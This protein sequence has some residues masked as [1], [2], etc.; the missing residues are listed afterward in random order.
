VITCAGKRLVQGNLIP[1]GQS[2]QKSLEKSLKVWQDLPAAERKAGAVQIGERGALDPK[3]LAQTAPAD[4]LVLRVYN[5]HLGRDAKG[6]LRFTVP[7]DYLPE[8]RR[9]AA[10][11]R[12]SAN[13]FMW[14][15]AKEWQAMVPANPKAGDRVPV[16]AT[17]AER[18]WRW[19]LDPATGMGEGRNFVDAATGTGHLNLVIEDVTA[20]NIQLRLEG[21]AKL[22]NPRRTLPASYE[23]ALVGHLT[24]DRSKKAFSRFDLV[25][26]GD[27]RGSPAGENRM[28]ERIGAQPL[29]IVFELAGPGA[30]VHLPAPRGARDHTER[31]L[32]PK[33]KATP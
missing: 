6:E 28:G 13:D 15:T 24:Y 30:S 27:V 11:F 4:C 3:R 26:L 25:A 21:S 14:V 8:F 12:E 22:E 2:F 32:S 29:G 10:R 23:P 1:D 7:E 33:L 9:H 17:F 20:A 19:H 5:R 18:L 16:P 31:Y